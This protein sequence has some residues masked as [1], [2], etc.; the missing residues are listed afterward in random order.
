MARRKKAQVW[1]IDFMVG[2]LIMIM[3][4]IIYYQYQGNLSDESEADWQ[5][6]TIDSKFISSSL[7]SGGYPL[8][9]TNETVETI[10]LT[11][12]N[13][14]INDTKIQ[15]FVNMS[16]KQAKEALRTRFNFYFFLQDSNGTSV[17]TAGLNATDQKFLVQTMRF[18]IYNS[19]VSR[20]VLY[21]WS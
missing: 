11:D 18:V 12:E 13:Y 2:L 10:G 20:M 3:A 7:M 1:Y 8:N 14:R 4:I 19:S 16:Y 21:V 6:M 17:Y 5:E 15:Q 9:W